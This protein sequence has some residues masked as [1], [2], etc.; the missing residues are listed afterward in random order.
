MKSRFLIPVLL[1]AAATL[2]ACSRAESQLADWNV[3]ATMP[4]EYTDGTAL[5]LSHLASWTISYSVN[6]GA[7]QTKVV[8]SLAAVT[9]TTIPKSLGTT[10]FQNFVT[11]KGAAPVPTSAWNTSS[12]AAPSPAVCVTIT[13]PPKP[14]TNLTVQ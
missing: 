14:P 9:S 6:G 1:A 13:G 7:V 3:Q 12:S 8:T 4:T 10:C 2:A 11:A 5:P